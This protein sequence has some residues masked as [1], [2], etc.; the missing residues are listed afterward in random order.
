MGYRTTALH[1]ALVLQLTGNGP[2]HLRKAAGAQIIPSWHRDVV[3]RNNNTWHPSLVSAYHESFYEY[4]LEGQYGAS[5]GGNSYGLE[6]C[7]W[8][9][10][11]DDRRM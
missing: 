3:T 9:S 4:R 7:I 5:N 10:V 11:K 8:I 6:T 1:G 2:P